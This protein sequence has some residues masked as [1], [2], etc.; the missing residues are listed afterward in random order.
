M[1]SM[2]DCSICRPP[3]TGKKHFPTRQT[4]VRRVES[5][6][7]YDNA[8]ITQIPGSPVIDQTHDGRGVNASGVRISAWIM[9]GL[10]L[11]GGAV[12]AGGKPVVVLGALMVA[13]GGASAAS[14]VLTR[15]FVRVTV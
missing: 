11:G 6:W 12:L 14:L 9:A 1:G 3:P 5:V 7:S 4:K 15:W 2:R 13:C 8:G 10:V